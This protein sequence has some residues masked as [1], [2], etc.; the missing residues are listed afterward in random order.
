[1]ATN[2]A[3]KEKYRQYVEKLIPAQ[4]RHKLEKKLDFD[5]NGV[6]TDLT[7]IAST[8]TNWEVNLATKL[9][10]T[11]TNIKDIKVIDSDPALQR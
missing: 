3:I 7:K 10:L 11:P 2:R 6:D 9:G 5:H 4:C 1:M 8:M